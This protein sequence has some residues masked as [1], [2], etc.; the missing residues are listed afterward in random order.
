[1]RI[2]DPSVT[3]DKE[4][5]STDFAAFTETEPAVHSDRSGCM[6]STRSPPAGLRLP[7]RV[8]VRTRES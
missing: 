3:E 4:I 8:A 6:G 5:L 2:R 1:M 7:N